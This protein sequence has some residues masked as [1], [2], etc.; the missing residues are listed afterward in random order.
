VLGLKIVREGLSAPDEGEAR[1]Q[2]HSFWLLALT[3]FATSIDAMAVGVG[4]AFIDANIWGVAAAIGFATFTMVTIGVMV[5]RGLAPC[6]QAGGVAG[7]GADGDRVVDFVRPPDG[8]RRL[9]SWPPNK[10][11]N[12]KVGVFLGARQALRDSNVRPT[13]WE[14]VGSAK[15]NVSIGGLQCFPDAITDRACNE[16]LPLQTFN[17]PLPAY[18][19]SACSRTPWCIPR[20]PPVRH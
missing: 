19:R 20:L 8:G 9:K 11:A 4:L 10:N 14:I 16:V 3:G 13:K 12:E 6:R 7:W 1:T 5:G 18:C 17:R 2:S 15:K